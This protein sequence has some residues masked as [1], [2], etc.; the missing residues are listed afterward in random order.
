[1]NTIFS[2]PAKIMGGSMNRRAFLQSSTA[3]I[4]LAVAS[5][6]AFAQEHLTAEQK[7]DFAKNFGLNNNLQA[8]F[9]AFQDTQ[10]A[11]P[12]SPRA[13][14][15]EPMLKIFR[16]Q[17][18]VKDKLY[19][20][21][22]FWHNLI[23]EF[24]SLDHVVN[25]G[26]PGQLQEIYAEQLGPHRSSWAFAI[27][28]I[29]MFEALNAFEGKYVSLTPSGYSTDLRSL[30][31]Q[32]AK[33]DNSEHV[34][35]DGSLITALSFASRNVIRQLYPKK[36]GH[37][38][39]RTD[40]LFLRDL[41]GLAGFVAGRKVGEAT[42]TI[43]LE[44]RGWSDAFGFTDG[45]EF[46]EPKASIFTSPDV[47]KWQVDPISK[48][49]TALG[50]L[51]NHVR[52]FTMATAEAFRC[53]PP[54]SY[55][56]PEFIAAYKEAKTAGAWGDNH[57]EDPGNTRY[58]TPT[59]RKGEVDIQPDAMGKYHP[60]ENE[61]FKAIFW[62]YDGTAFLCAPPRL[63]NMIATTYARQKLL[64]KD[65]VE[66]CRYLALV[67]IALGDAG[68][69]AWEAKFYYLTPRPI[70]YLRNRNADSTPEGEGDDK[71]TPLGAAISNAGDN[72]RNLT[73]PFPSYPSGHAVFG[74]AIF[75]LLRLH[76]AA[77]GVADSGFTFVSDEYNGNNHSPGSPKGRPLVEVTFQN[78]SEPEEENGQ[79]R[80]WMG[81][82]WQF[83]KVQGIRQGNN[84][85]KHVFNTT[86]LKANA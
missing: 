5:K 42:A 74:G 15:K 72:G 9:Q 64:I 61:S 28:H 11:I 3:I 71:W 67:N 73:P 83:D 7:T 6:A 80:I 86:Y 47:G 77:I 85:A 8:Q 58:N 66:L 79:S 36:K 29:A 48:I 17:A 68:I 10:R 23:L 59:T 38:Q 41:P 39:A 82:H 81:I 33:L 46:P 35:Q 49:G 19:S 84:I 57:A 65:G 60:K 27:Y 32:K 2:V 75:E 76:A 44:S 20:L 26:Q 43:V 50:G 1:M 62:G 34:P 69:S 14:A 54:P 53:S 16:E 52:P 25:P 18:Q 56:S 22:E 21:V 24:T 30:I 40:D 51:W 4:S 78:L 70:T 45:S 31:L 55:D 37:L 63:Y 12:F 13:F